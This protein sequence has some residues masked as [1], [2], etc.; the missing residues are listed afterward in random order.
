MDMP[1]QPPAGAQPDAS[2]GDDGGKTLAY[3]IELYVFKNG[4]Y[5][6]S[7][8]DASQEE[9]EHEATNTPEGANGQDFDKLGDALGAI[10]QMVKS[11]PAGQDAG[12]QLEAGY[13]G[14]EPPQA[15]PIRGQ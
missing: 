8:E 4:T 3:C 10:L 6:V 1:G 14:K 9:A 12:A 15:M 5:K 11:N 13:S 7:R 2:P